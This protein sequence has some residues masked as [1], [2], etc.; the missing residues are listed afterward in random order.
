MKN[1]I[2]ITKDGS[3]IGQN[4][5]SLILK[6]RYFLFQIIKTN[7]KKFYKQT[8]LGPLWAIINP[9]VFTGVF[10]IIFGKVANLSTDGTPQF[11]FYFSSMV[12][13][14]LFRTSLTKNIDVF[15]SA[16]PILYI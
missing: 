1:K 6:W 13:W 4:N 5:L 10:T 3:N 15:L 12:I 11:L 16:L 8:V 9:I 7:F 2:I 14:T